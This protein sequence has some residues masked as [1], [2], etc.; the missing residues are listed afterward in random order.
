VPTDA[1]SRRLGDLHLFSKCVSSE[2]LLLGFKV[3]VGGLANADIS[4]GV[5]VCVCI[6]CRS[7]PD[8][9]AMHILCVLT[10]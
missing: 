1:Y 9:M 4:K 3:Y 5:C 10:G 6:I 7:V 8:I 2:V